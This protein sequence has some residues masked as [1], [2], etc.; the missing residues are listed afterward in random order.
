MKSLL[1]EERTDSFPKISIIWDRFPKK[2]SF[3]FAEQTNAQISLAI[4]TP[5]R[6]LV[7]SF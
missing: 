2:T 6:F 3:S 4:K 7:S 1:R 5:S